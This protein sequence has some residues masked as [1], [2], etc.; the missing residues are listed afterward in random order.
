M[1]HDFPGNYFVENTRSILFYILLSG[2]IVLGI[3]E[4]LRLRFDFFQK[5]FLMIAGKLIKPSEKNKMNAT[6]PFFLGLLLSAGFFLKEIA[7]LGS[8]F[9]MVG[10]PCAAWFGEKFG[11]HK[12]HNGK[13]YEGLVA[14]ILGAFFAGLFF[15]I[16]NGILEPDNFFSMQMKTSLVRV[17]LF[18]LTG[19]VFG[20]VVELYSSTG[21]LDDNLLIPVASGLVMS[22]SLLLIFNLDINRVFYSAKDLILPK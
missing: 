1:L 21:F 19:A 9:L 13:S 8:L 3:I 22:F 7:I 20:F 5:L 2:F 11:K 16:L 12:L 17:L 6:V 15:L 10:D 18:L 4:F 14:G